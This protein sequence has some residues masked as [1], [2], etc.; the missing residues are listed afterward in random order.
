MKNGLM[1][2][3][4]LAALFSGCAVSA[5][6]QVVISQVYG[7]GG[8]SGAPVRSDYIELHNNSAATVSVDGWSVQY[9]S[10]AGSSWQRTRSC[11]QHRRRRLLPGQAGRRR[12]AA[13]PA[14][15]TPDATGT[16]AMAGGAGKVALVNS[17][18]SLTGTCPTGNI[19]FVGFGTT[20]NCAEGSA[21]TPAPSNTLAVL[22]ADG[23]CT[24]S[25]NNGADFATGAP[26]RAI[27]HHAANVA[28]AA[29]RPILS[30]ADASADEA[31]GSLHLRPA[32]EPAGRRRWS[33]RAYATA[34]G[35][36]TRRPRLCRGQRHDRIRGGERHRQRR[37]KPCSTTP[38]PKADETFCLLLERRH[39][40][41]ARR[42]AGTGHDR[43]RR[44]QPDCRSTRSRAAAPLRRSPARSSTPVASSPA[45]RATASSCRR[46]TPTP[47]PTR[48]RRK[49]CSSS[50]ARP[51]GRGP[52]SGNA[53]RVQ[54]TVSRIRAHRRSRASRR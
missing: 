14:L 34:D 33:Q 37:R 22:R 35:T 19:D 28:A 12:H 13:A 38:V 7:G 36:A 4:A 40:R 46:R 45:A 18:T 21:P 39:R 11:R 48:P 49:A 2:H 17:T 8:N 42:C 15:P 52:Q 54:G 6:A 23:G 43:Q 24:D 16:I 41:V 32:P 3:L 31:S 27:A 1:R 20:A 10:A 26:P 25:N 30:V 53:V 51:A 44:L 5:Q 47:M 50:P 9:A 29:A